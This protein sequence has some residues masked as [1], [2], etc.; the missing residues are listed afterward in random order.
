MKKR[1]LMKLMCSFFFILFFY[2]PVHGVNPITALS[3]SIT[4][5]K[6]NKA[7]NQAKYDQAEAAYAQLLTQ[8]PYNAQH[9]YN[10][11]VTSYKQT[12]FDDAHQAFNKAILHAQPH[13]K[14]QEQAYFN[15]GNC[16]VQENK[17]EDAIKDYKKTLEIN[18]QNE[19]AAHNLKIV[20]QM[21][22][23]KNKENNQ[24]KKNQDQKNQKDQ[25]KDQSKQDQQDQNNSDDQNQSNTESSSEKNRDQKEPKSDDRNQQSSDNKQGQQKKQQEDQ[26]QAPQDPSDQLKK[27]EQK[28]NQDKKVDHNNSQKKSLEKKEQE[29][30]KLQAPS[31]QKNDETISDSIEDL[32]D[33]MAQ[34]INAK[35]SDDQRLEK[36]S[37]A[38]LEKLDEHEKN[39]QKKLLQLNVTKQGA[40][41]H[42]QKNW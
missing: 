15:R 40:Q 9:Y 21:L 30:S 6:A 3:N 20:E 42:G 7:M 38:L 37:V 4:E 19:Q 27:S 33:A 10:S 39:I 16:C 22:K 31:S 28:N 8:D 35:I 29:E 1:N 24:N 18:P 36:R 23:Q 5:Y 41:K 25:N 34:Q 11:G 32:H 2:L 14:I 12:K 26:H 17:L 13:G